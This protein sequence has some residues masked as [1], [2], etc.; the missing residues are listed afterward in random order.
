[1]QPGV[2]SLLPDDPGIEVDVVI[3][4]PKGSFL[5][6]GL[7]GSIDFVSPLPCPYNSGAVPTRL[8]LEGDLLDALIL[9]PRLRF[10]MR[11]CLRAWGAITLTNRGLFDDKL[12]CCAD[13]PSAQQIHNVLRFFPLLCALQ[14]GAQPV[15]RPARTQRQRA[16][17]RCGRGDGAG[18]SASRRCARPDRPLLK[19]GM[20]HRGN[21]LISC[22]SSLRQGPSIVASKNASCT[23]RRLPSSDRRIGPSRPPAKRR[24]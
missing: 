10:G 15:A 2:A 9:G 4:V 6:R 22:G 17:V 8:G 13:M 5:K 19:H 3:E 12:I 16:L 7:G 11:L 14:G 21:H 20:P 1:M 23:L 24:S 18:A